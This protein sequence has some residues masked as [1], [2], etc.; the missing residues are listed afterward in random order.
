M[1]NTT[2][3]KGDKSQLRRSQA[4]IA[5]SRMTERDRQIL[6]MLAKHHVLTTHQ[7]T[8]LFFDCPRVARRRVQVL[9]QVGLVD[10]FRPI[11]PLGSAPRHCV[12]TPLGGLATE[13]LIDAAHAATF[14]KDAVEAIAVRPDLGHLVGVN[15]V[16]T[17]LAEHAR[18]HV[19]AELELWWSER[20]C[21]RTLG[22]Y[23]R[24]DGFGR[25]REANRS[26]DFFLEFDT[27]T[28]PLSTVV[29][30][31]DGYA[32]LAD[33]TGRTA[34]VLF[35]LHS[36]RRESE[37]HRRLHADRVPVATASGSPATTDPAE[38]VWRRAGAG[39]GSR[40]RLIEVL[41]PHLRP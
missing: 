27:G 26:I 11:L 31:L 19:D 36:E 12:I 18:R 38:M 34:P 41:P 33:A 5:A 28:E 15:D 6:V 32:S 3:N 8:R 39:R 4:A 37:L 35:W 25:W 24:P 2:V 23:I 21:T 16:F 30:K 1:T 13:G 7:I 22:T 17:R 14:R 10:T 9:Q 40:C 20:A 29:A